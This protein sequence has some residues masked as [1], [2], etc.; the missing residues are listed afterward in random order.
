MKLRTLQMLKSLI[1]AEIVLNA[2]Q[3]EVQTPLPE[4]LPQYMPTTHW[5]L[6]SL[7]CHVWWFERAPSTVL[8]KSKSSA[9]LILC[10]LSAVDMSLL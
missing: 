3:P 7:L 9:V 1:R 8:S 10:G 6:D 5:Y 2:I 4:P